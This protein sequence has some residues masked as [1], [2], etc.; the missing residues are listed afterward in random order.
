MIQITPL[1]RRYLGR[2]SGAIGL[3]YRYK[4]LLEIRL[5]WSGLLLRMNTTLPITKND[6]K[7]IITSAT[8]DELDTNSS[9]TDQPF[10]EI[11]ND[12]HCLLDW[13]DPYYPQDPSQTVV[14]EPSP[15]VR[16]AIRS[17]LKDDE[18]L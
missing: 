16:A 8:F 10:N 17:C 3:S 11:E 13:L 12:L 5:Q 7:L 18:M 4:L 14:T 1:P 15:R 9:S 2:S 6:I